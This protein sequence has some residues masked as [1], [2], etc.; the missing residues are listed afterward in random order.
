MGWRTIKYGK[1]D[2]IRRWGLCLMAAFVAVFIQG[3]FE[4][5]HSGPPAI[6]LYAIFAM[7]TIL[8]HLN[9]ELDS[10]PDITSAS[11]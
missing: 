5:T 4:N 1:D 9:M 2:F 7:M 11:S 10:Q 6:V 3:M 8:W